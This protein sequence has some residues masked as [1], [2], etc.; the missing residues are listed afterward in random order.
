LTQKII[1][2]RC[3]R[4]EISRKRLGCK[5][6]WQEKEIN[7]ESIENKQLLCSE[8]WYKLGKIGTACYNLND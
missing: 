8:I 2:Y 5:K 3:D 7:P 1:E 4:P 6:V